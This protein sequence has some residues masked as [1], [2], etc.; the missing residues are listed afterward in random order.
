ST[1]PLLGVQAALG[2]VLAPDDDPHTVVLGAA[3]WRRRFQADPA[4]VGRTVV[5]D[6]ETHTVVGVLPDAFQLPNVETEVIAPID[7][8]VDPRR[9][10]RGSNF[11]RAFA[12]LAPGATLPQAR[13]DLAAIVR[14]L[15]R[16]YPATDAKTTAPRLVP[17]D[18]ELV[19]AY[20]PTLALLAAAVLAVLAVACANFAGL[21]LA[22]SVGRRVELAIRTALGATRGQ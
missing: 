5:L 14:D 12:R 22:R 20:R 11:L 2:R 1:F 8:A 18:D 3:L 4:I 10:Q 15:V 16:S 21:S 13:D 17:I 6:G 7:F 19:G 9:E